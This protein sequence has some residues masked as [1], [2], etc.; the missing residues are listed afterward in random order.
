MRSVQ[1]VPDPDK[2]ETWRFQVVT[3]WLGERD[4]SMDNEARLRQVKEKA[5]RLC[6]PFK[7]A[8]LWM[9][10]DTLVT[11]DPLG[12]WSPVA[13]DSKGGRVT[14]AGD[15]AHAMTPRKIARPHMPN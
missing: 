9:P 13:R 2:P 10:D 12:Y 8:N 15:A 6:E 5:S 1:D 7:S 4:S 11:Y 14:L 3:S